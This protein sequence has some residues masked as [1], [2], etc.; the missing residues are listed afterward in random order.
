MNGEVVIAVV[1][2][3]AIGVAYLERMHLKAAAKK[4][5]AKGKAEMAAEVAKV[6]ADA[7]AEAEKLIRCV[8]G[9]ALSVVT[10]LEAD[11]RKVI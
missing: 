3:V 4:E 9:D 11:L 5:I 6:I 10:K 8:S 2:V 7:K 1:A